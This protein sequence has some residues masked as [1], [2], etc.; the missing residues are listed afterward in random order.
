MKFTKFCFTAL[1][2]SVFG[3]VRKLDSEIEYS[4]EPQWHSFP[5]QAMSRFQHLNINVREILVLWLKRVIAVLSLSGY[6]LWSM[7]HM[8]TNLRG[9]A[10]ASKIIHLK[11]DWFC[12]V[13]GHAESNFTPTL[14]YW[15]F[16]HSKYFP[17]LLGLFP[18]SVLRNLGQAVVN[19]QG[20]LSK[21]NLP[22]VDHWRRAESALFVLSIDLT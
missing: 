3:E 20:F 18:L 12:G 8:T 11:L 14:S 6:C 13:L 4:Y 22:V 17:S 1:H 2:S 9:T 15:L 16:F 19:W 5:A 21:V 7:A 10:P